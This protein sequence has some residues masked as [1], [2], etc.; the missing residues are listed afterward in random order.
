MLESYH[1]KIILFA[2]TGFQ[3]EKGLMIHSIRNYHNKKAIGMVT[4]HSAVN[5]ELE[6]MEAPENKLELEGY[7]SWKTDLADDN[8]SD[9]R[10]SSTQIEKK[11]QKNE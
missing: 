6:E 1:S 11:K 4:N 10:G 8:Y 3:T 5:F 7:L 9:A 2:E